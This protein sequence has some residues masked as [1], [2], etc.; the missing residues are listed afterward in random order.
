MRMI[1]REQTGNW[2][3]VASLAHTERS[4][5][6]YDYGVGGGG[7]P[8]WKVQFPMQPLSPNK[9][10]YLC[11]H[12][13]NLCSLCNI[14]CMGCYIYILYTHC[15][16]MYYLSSNHAISSDIGQLDEQAI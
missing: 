13:R 5:S 6:E 2:Y 14:V 8:E 12:Y 11:V 4:D 15:T 9:T 7:G 3:L 1:C 10:V 16:T